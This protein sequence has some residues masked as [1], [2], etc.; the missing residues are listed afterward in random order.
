MPRITGLVYTLDL[1]V[2]TGFAKGKPGGAPVSGTVRLKKPSDPIEVAF[3][4]LIAFLQQ[5]FSAELPALL[6]KERIMSLEAFKQ[7]NMG[8]AVVYAHAGYHG[9]VEGMCGRYGIPW[10][11]IPDSTARKHFI[12]KGR[13]GDR[14]ETK[15]AVVERCHVLQLMPR[16]CDDDNRAD[17]L[18]IHDWACATLGGRAASIENF[19]LF[20][21]GERRA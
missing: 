9:I 15:N 6:V 16:D 12:G 8:Q 1:G 2:S 11:D 17:A 18:C 10:R 4:N 5:E 20:G 19:Q 21:Q 14:D 3:S 13:L 7:L